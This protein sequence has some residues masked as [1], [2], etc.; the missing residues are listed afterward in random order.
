LDIFYLGSIGETIVESRIIPTNMRVNVVLDVGRSY[1]LQVIS[2]TGTV[3]RDYFN[4]GSTLDYNFI[5]GAIVFTGAVASFPLLR[6]QATRPLTTRLAFAYNDSSTTTTFIS[7]FIYNSSN[8]EVFNTTYSA[9]NFSTFSYNWNSAIATMNYKVVVSATSGT[10]GTVGLTE[11]LLA[12]PS[13]V[14]RF[15]LSFIGLTTTDI[16]PTIFMV[17]MAAIFSA[18]TAG[19]GM[20]ILVA[21]AGVLYLMGW[22][23][24]ATMSSKII[25]LS[26]VTSLECYGC[27]TERC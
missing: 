9:A 24:P 3:Y 25:L 10:Y 23:N 7:I 8:I 16:L 22:I 2:Q 6:L 19:V 1:I 13:Y 11:I 12:N 15:N 18:L 14:N 26:M 17:S 5:L 27:N 21:F 4:C 20:V